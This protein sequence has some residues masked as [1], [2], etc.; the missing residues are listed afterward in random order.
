MQFDFYLSCSVLHFSSACFAVFYFNLGG[1]VVDD[2]VNY[3]Y[4]C[5]YYYVLS[6]IHLFH[7]KVALVLEYD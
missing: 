1:W 4:H 5:Y 6:I 3:H 2:G 7:V